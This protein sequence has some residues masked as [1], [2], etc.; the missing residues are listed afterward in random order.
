MTVVSRGVYLAL[1]SESSFL[2][3]AR[4]AVCV[5]NLA[6]TIVHASYCSESFLGSSARLVFQFDSCCYSSARLMSL[7]DPCIRCGA[8]FMLFANVAFTNAC[9]FCLFANLDIHKG[10]MV[11]AMLAL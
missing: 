7:S 4:H 11:N 5:P 9:L 10:E 6:F 8:S 1:L 3:V 2:T